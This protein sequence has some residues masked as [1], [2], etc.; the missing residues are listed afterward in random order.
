VDATLAAY[1]AA[2]L[3]LVITP[4]ASTTVVIRNALDGGWR[5]GV[6]TAVGIAVANS[7]YAALTGA[8]ITAL[9]HEMPATLVAIRVAGAA[10]L[11]WLGLSSLRR[12]WA[13]GRSLQ[14]AS[15]GASATSLAVSFR[16]GVTVNLLNPAAI[17]FY[18]VVVP[19]FLPSPAPT[20][21]YV[22]FA[23]IHVTLALTCH[24]VWSA[25]FD[26]VRRSSGQMT[27]V[28]VLDVVAGVALLA[29]AVQAVVQ[30]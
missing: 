5:C 29:L 22:L 11:A 6:A 15:I 19:G 27:I 28:R 2:T 16:E 14:P 13:G 1:V 10:Y 23:T 4:G 21:R 24:I 20:G 17:T 30:A 9:L 8:G 3:A 26:R 12:A 18:L 25:L 7:T